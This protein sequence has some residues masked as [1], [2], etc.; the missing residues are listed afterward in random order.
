MMKTITDIYGVYAD[1]IAAGIKPGKPDLAY[2]YVPKVVGAAGVF[3]TN[4][5]QAACV[6]YTRKV[7]KRHLVKAVII[8]A[9]NANAATGDLGMKNARLTAQKAAT[10]LGILPTEV[11]V[12]STG[13][14][15]V[16][17]P[18]DKMES[19]L[20]RLLS[21]PPTHNGEAAATAIMTTDLV[22]KHAFAEAKIGKKIF[23]VAGIAKGSG[24]IAPN[25]ATM[26]GFITTNA[27]LDSPT[28][29]RVLKEVVADTFNQIS[30]DTDTS[31]NDMV[32][33][34]A[35]GEHQFPET[36]KAAMAQFKSLLYDVCCDLAK[37]IA[38]DGEGATKLIEVE[39]VRA[40]TRSDA[41]AIAHSVMNSPLVKTAIHGADPNWGRIVAA[42]G[43][44]QNV[45][46]NP[47]K[48]DIS[49]GGIEVFKNGSPVSFDRA[50]VVALLKHPDVF[51]Q[52]DLKLATGSAKVWGCDLTKGYIDINTEYS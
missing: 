51:I 32:L 25:M 1:G 11:A 5:F 34:F 45:K 17:L 6:Q 15:G 14:I 48:V 12:A 3:T 33:A 22:P 9:G 26:L 46:L 13:I 23:Q 42:I 43:K 8:N 10:L 29:T 2:I 30:V 24:M 28:L 7:M 18:M 36:D 47:E 16:Q 50:A 38:R 31:T 19:G 37:A 40:A 21:G 44:T 35:T 20:D 41:T 4:R 49:F 52:I 39:V 27:T